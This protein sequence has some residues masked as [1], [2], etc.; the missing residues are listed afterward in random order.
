LQN[1]SFVSP[2]KPENE[3]TLK[4]RKGGE[5]S[6][7]DS[8]FGSAISFAFTSTQA[9]AGRINSTLC[10]VQMHGNDLQSRSLLLNNKEG[11]F[12]FISNCHG[13]AFADVTFRI[14]SFLQYF[15]SRPEAKQNNLH[16]VKGKDSFLHFAYGYMFHGYTDHYMGRMFNRLQ[17][18]IESGIHKLFDDW[19][20]RHLSV[21]N[22]EKNCLMKWS[23]I[24]FQWIATLITIFFTGCS[25]AF[26]IL[27]VEFFSRKIF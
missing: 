22:I 11:F 17:R 19:L 12:K 2:A 1:F 5:F 9:R 25:L 13:R 21:K 18:I 10:P 16:F 7:T 24:S 8:F 23:P 27:L 15:N 4:G 3:F 20:N 6:I 26:V 14:D